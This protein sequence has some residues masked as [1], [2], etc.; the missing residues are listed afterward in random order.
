MSPHLI[1]YQNHSG[2]T[3]TGLGSVPATHI[4]HKHKL[5]GYY[6]SDEA[7]ELPDFTV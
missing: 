4:L 6:V 1:M 5:N 3:G 7:T 2:G